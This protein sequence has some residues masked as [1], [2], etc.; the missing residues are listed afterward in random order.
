[1]E[2]KDILGFG[3]DND[4]TAQPIGI[5]GAENNELITLSLDELELFQS[6]LKELKKF[7]I[8]LESIT[9]TKLTRKDAQSYKNRL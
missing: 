5:A 6:I 1:M 8:Q 4:S 3:K 9:N 7:N 2:N